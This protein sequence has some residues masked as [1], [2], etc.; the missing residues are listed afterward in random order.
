MNPVCVKRKGIKVDLV[1]GETYYYC[2]CGLSKNQPFCDGSH[3]EREGYKPLKF[4]HDGPTKKRKL[5]LCK[6][7]KEVS[8]AMCDHMHKHDEIDW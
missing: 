4:T 1:K 7:N 2:T 5:C 3:K 8:G 6:R